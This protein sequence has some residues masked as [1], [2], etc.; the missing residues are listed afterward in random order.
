MNSELA[1]IQNDQGKECKLR[2]G[3]FCL[4]EALYSQIVGK[5]MCVYIWTL[6]LHRGGASRFEIFLDFP[7]NGGPWFVNRSQ[8]LQFVLAN[9]GQPFPN[10]FVHQSDLLDVII[11]LGS[12]TPGIFCVPATNATAR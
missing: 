5:M 6:T 9:G 2:E 1:R 4:T 7:D 8:F 10:V 3:H 12:L 11:S